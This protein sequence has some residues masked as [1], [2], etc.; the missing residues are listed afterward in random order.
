MSRTLVIIRPEPGG[1]ATVAEAQGLG[2]PVLLEPLFSIEPRAW[3]PP[4]PDEIDAL[5]IGS[6]NA[7]RHGGEALELFR[8][9]PVHAVG[10]A[11][12]RA[13][14]EA[15]FEV[16]GVGKGHLQP[17]LDGLAGQEL[18]MLRLTGEEHV[19][20]TP[21]GGIGIVTRVVYASVALPMP[22]HLASALAE[23]C[24]VLL[25]S[26]VAALHF[27]AECDRLGVDRSRIAVAALAPRIA[28][29]AGEGWERVATAETPS[30]AA[31]LA[32]ARDMCHF[33]R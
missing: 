23:G 12:A 14:R 17:V 13:A 33:A 18:R 15:G 8:E 1:S 32:L 16:A 26:G 11:T 22:E 5:L 25:H 20:V 6:A 7:I 3:V 24:I 31:L 2:F 29:T 21:P 4:P 28:E 9:K 30:D 10:G 19:A 27:R